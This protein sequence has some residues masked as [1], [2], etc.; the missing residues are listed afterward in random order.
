MFRSVS[1]MLTLSRR[2]PPTPK[3]PS[4]TA[5]SRRSTSAARFSVVGTAARN[6][7]TS[8]FRFRYL[9]DRPACHPIHHP[10]YQ[11]LNDIVMPMP[12]RII[13]LAVKRPVLVVAQG[14]GVQPVGRCK[15]VPPG[16][17][18]RHASPRY[19]THNSFVSCTRTEY[20]RARPV[21]SMWPS[22][23]FQMS[24]A[25]FSTVGTI[26]SNGS[27]SRFSSRWS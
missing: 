17:V 14:R 25:I 19:S 18:H 20:S 9:I 24:I 7:A 2:G 26:R 8:S 1:S 3:R 23:R 22:S 13:A 11:Q 15:T 16:E 10:A 21:A 6:S 27:T 4:Q 5:R 12:V